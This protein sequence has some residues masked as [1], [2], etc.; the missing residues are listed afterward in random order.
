M[1]VI[2]WDGKTLA[3]DKLS[4]DGWLN[5]TTTKIRRAPSGEL[6]GWAGVASV[7]RELVEW[8]LAGAKPEKYPSSNYDKENPS[9]LMVVGL[10]K[11]VR[12]YEAGP[13]PIC[14]EDSAYVLGSG[15]DA[16]KAV[17]ALGYDAV[18]AVEIASIV[19]SGCGYGVDTLTLEET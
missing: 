4:S 19:C 12:V 5:S 14:Y 9:R 6:I 3:A 2:A 10:D 8:Y 15:R 17:M 13:Y 18:K 7:S 16:A 11:S 1:T